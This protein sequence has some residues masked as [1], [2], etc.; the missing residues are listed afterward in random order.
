MGFL[1]SIGD[2]IGGITKSIGNVFDPVAG[3]AGSVLG[4]TGQQSANAA[5]ISAVRDQMEFQER[6]SNTAYQ[7]A[8]ADMSKAGLN[9]ILAY[10]QGGAT[11]PGGAAPVVLNPF[12][13]FAQNLNNSMNSAYDRR[14]TSERIR[15]ESINREKVNAEIG[16]IQE[17]TRHVNM[18]KTFVSQQVKKLSW[19]LKS[20]PENYQ[21][22]IERLALEALSFERKKI[23]E[24]LK[25]RATN[26]TVGEIERTVKEQTEDR[27]RTFMD[28]FYDLIGNERMR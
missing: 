12:Q 11:T 4:F 14:L 23:V 6:M 10:K 28:W 26:L 2:A 27:K 9:P 20:A 13:G 21:R 3:L 16:K 7:R 18:M 1:S 5:N 8:M 22:E 24:R 25:N 17:D 19:E 15:T